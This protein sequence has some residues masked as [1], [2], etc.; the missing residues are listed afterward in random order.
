[1]IDHALALFP[2]QLNRD[3][4]TF[5][6]F[7]PQSG[8]SQFSSLGRFQPRLAVSGE[9]AVSVRAPTIR[10]IRNPLAVP[11]FMLSSYVVRLLAGSSQQ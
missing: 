4:G 7:H 2:I 5:D 3:T 11:T 10:P 1:M 6:V 9:E 8:H